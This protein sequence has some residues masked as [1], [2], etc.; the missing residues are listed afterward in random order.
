LIERSTATRAL[1]LF[2]DRADLRVH[3]HGRVLERDVEARITGP[4]DVARGLVDRQLGQHALGDRLII[5]GEQRGRDSDRAAELL[6]AR[7]P[8]RVVVHRDAG[9][10]VDERQPDREIADVAM[11]GVQPAAPGQGASLAHE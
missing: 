4:E 8:R 7:I 10:R 3:V 2:G 6:E 1:P 9:H 11:R 5:A